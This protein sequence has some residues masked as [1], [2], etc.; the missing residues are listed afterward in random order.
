MDE[1]EIQG[2][3]YISSKRASQLTGYAKDYIGQLARGGKL[4]GTRVGRAWYVDE[5]ALKALAGIVGDQSAAQEP[6]SSLKAS[7][8]T[9]SQDVT[10]HSVRALTATT[11]V[12]FKTWSSPTYYHDRSPLSP[13][14]NKGKVAIHIDRSAAN[15]S[16]KPAITIH[17]TKVGTD[18]IT[19]VL[20]PQKSRG[21]VKKGNYIPHLAV[22]TVVVLIVLIGGALEP[23]MWSFSTQTAD[24]SAAENLFVDIFNSGV[25]LIVTF[26]TYFWSQFGSFF[27]TGLLF[28][29]QLFHLG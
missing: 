25:T 20:E 29:L 19:K 8:P 21:A 26:C 27:S 5:E 6:H 4:P 17:A 13:I 28:I 15:F 11:P 14:I 24:I 22:A 10:I 18:H 9:L 7:T 1:L 16:A 12:V 2:K 3:K 23:S